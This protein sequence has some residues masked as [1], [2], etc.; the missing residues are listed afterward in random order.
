MEGRGPRD[1][2]CQP[3][4]LEPHFLPLFPG[5]VTFLGSLHSY[6]EHHFIKV[7]LLLRKWDTLEGM[8]LAGHFLLSEYGFHC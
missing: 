4:I 2:G 5:L 8:A 6:Q 7:A 1:W 3:P